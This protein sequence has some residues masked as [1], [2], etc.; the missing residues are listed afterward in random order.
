M[1]AKEDTDAVASVLD[2]FSEKDEV[3]S[4]IAALPTIFHDFRLVESGL[5]RWTGQR[6]L[7][8]CRSKCSMIHACTMYCS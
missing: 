1:A 6:R 4:L 2:H 8:A 7:N 5:E 3:V